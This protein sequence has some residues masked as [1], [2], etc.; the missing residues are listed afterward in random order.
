MKGRN[1]TAAEKA[2]MNT[3]A[4]YGCYCCRELGIYNDYILLHH[5]Q[6]RTKPNAHFHVIP[7]C[8]KHHDYNQPEGLHANIGAWRKKWGRE[9]EVIEKLFNHFYNPLENQE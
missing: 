9:S 6:G 7:L 4:E 5:T 8:D 2:W 3:V 1:P